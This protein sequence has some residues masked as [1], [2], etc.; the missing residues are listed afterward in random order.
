VYGSVLIKA[1]SLDEIVL[2][3]YLFSKNGYTKENERAKAT[4][5]NVDVIRN[6]IE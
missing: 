1:E 6:I 3:L 5:A 4:R 2:V